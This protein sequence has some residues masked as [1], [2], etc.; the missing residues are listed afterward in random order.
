VKL[1][2][3]LVAAENVSPPFAGSSVT[4]FFTSGPLQEE[5]HRKL[6]WALGSTTV[7]VRVIVS[8]C[9]GVE[10]EMTMLLMSGDVVCTVPPCTSCCMMRATLVSWFL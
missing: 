8:P 2:A 3:R 10:S 6:S 5:V 4:P 9:A 1:V 7:A